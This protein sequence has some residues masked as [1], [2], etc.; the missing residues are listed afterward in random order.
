[1]PK[2]HLKGL[3]WREL[4]RWGYLICITKEVVKHQKP[5]GSVE[6]WTKPQVFR[7]CWGELSA[8]GCA[9]SYAGAVA[10]L[11]PSPTGHVVGG[12]EVS[13]EDESV[14]TECWVKRQSWDR[15][16]K[17][18]W[19]TPRRLERESNLPSVWSF[20][21]CQPSCQH[22]WMMG[23]GRMVR[24]WWGMPCGGR[25]AARTSLWGR[26]PKYGCVPE[27]QGSFK[28]L[29]LLLDPTP[30]KVLFQ[31]VEEGKGRVE[32]D[33]QTWVQVILRHNPKQP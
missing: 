18:K 14:S 10:L 21:S 5:T 20:S 19:Q 8:L 11:S 16:Q 23:D 15:K 22:S 30:T 31:K 27:S 28:I 1:M 26:S 25:P 7:P 6:S 24:G 29:Y 12:E 13:P 33:F 2:G 4:C 3:V 32:S 17:V 9:L